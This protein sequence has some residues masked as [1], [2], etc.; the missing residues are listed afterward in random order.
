MPVPTALVKANV[1]SGYL[2]ISAAGNDTLNLLSSS[3]SAVSTTIKGGTG[4]DVVSLY[5]A[6]DV[7]LNVSSGDSVFSGTGADTMLFT[8]R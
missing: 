4:T 2:D 5:G 7:V 1:A 3:A 6:S 8:D